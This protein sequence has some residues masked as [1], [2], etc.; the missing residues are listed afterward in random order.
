MQHTLF[1]GASCA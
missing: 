1:L